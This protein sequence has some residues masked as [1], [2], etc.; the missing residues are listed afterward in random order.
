MLIRVM[1]TDNSF[2]MVRPE[3][4][5]LLLEKGSVCSFLRRD[6]WVM[7]EVGNMRRKNSTEYSG[8]DRRLSRAEEGLN[9]G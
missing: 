3:M 8:S 9:I 6:G 5:D 2:D 7:P 4:L 1:Y